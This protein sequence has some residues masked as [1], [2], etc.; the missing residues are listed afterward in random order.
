MGGGK[1]FMR[2]TESMASGSVMCASP[3]VCSSSPSSR[4]SVANLAQELH[5]PRVGQPFFGENY[6][7][8]EMGLI[9]NVSGDHT[10]AQSC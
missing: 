3:V 5:P 2:S 4:E 7:L 9:V 1:A 6:H 10:P 8:S